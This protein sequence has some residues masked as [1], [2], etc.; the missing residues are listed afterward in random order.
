MRD[1]RDPGRVDTG[2]RKK[3]A[4]ARDDPLRYAARGV[5]RRRNLDASNER[6]AMRV[7]RNDVGKGSSNVDS[8][9]QAE[10]RCRFSD[11]V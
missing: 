5:M 4:N 10:G 8:D 6:A 3:L 2:M 7:D 9:A 1:K 11:R